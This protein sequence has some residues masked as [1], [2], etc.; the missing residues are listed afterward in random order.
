LGKIESMSK[1]GKEPINPV[2]PI[3]FEDGSGSYNG[4]TKREFFAGLAMQGILSNEKNH[5]TNSHLVYV[6]IA[7]ADELLKQ[8]NDE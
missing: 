5:A 7:I 8:L 4:L 6:S 1:L 2:N 3:K